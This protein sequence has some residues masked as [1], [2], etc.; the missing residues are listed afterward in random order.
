MNT[1]IATSPTAPLVPPQACQITTP[2]SVS[3]WHTL[4][5]SHPLCDLVH[6]YLKGITHGFQIGFNYAESALKSEKKNLQSANE[7]PEVIDEYPQKEVDEL[8]V[9][10][11][12]PSTMVPGVHVS[13][14][15][16]IPKFYQPNKWWLIVDLSYH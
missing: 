10:G 5:V 6:F 3:A 1:H 7:H 11:P 9:V 2:L 15:G 13:R 14:F 8:R 16:V 12:F 4:L